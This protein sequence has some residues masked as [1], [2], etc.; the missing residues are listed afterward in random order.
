MPARSVS[1]LL[2][3]DHIEYNGEDY[4]YAEHDLIPDGVI[5]DFSEE[6]EVVIADS[7]CDPYGK[8]KTFEAYFC[9]NDD[10]HSYIYYGSA[11]F[12]NDMDLA[13]KGMYERGK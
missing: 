5:P 3:Y 7:K 9:E 11:H 13:V 2:L 8:D 12:V 4:Y 10:G 1:G 6:I